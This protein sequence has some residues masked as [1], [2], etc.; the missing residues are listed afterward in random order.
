MKAN[1]DKSNPNGMYHGLIYISAS[2]LIALD[3]LD[4]KIGPIKT[5]I[6][7]LSGT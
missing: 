4:I 5:G 7:P 6:L 1:L 3:V 2:S